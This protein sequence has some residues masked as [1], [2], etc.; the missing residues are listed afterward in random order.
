MCPE[1]PP[2][3]T[4]QT[5][6]AGAGLT[7]GAAEQQRWLHALD[8]LAAALSL[9]TEGDDSKDRFAGLAVRLAQPGEGDEALQGWAVA[10]DSRDEAL[11]QQVGL[12]AARLATAALAPWEGS[13]GPTFFMSVSAYASRC[14]AYARTVKRCKSC[15]ALLA[16]LQEAISG[17]VSALASFS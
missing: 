12:A 14:H 8:M 15:G 6:Q 9:L 4:L 10:A 1:P 7:A 13:V 16:A 11:S 3:Q 17:L 5:L 2:E